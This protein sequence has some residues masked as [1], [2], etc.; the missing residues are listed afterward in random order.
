MKLMNT[1]TLLLCLFHKIL[2]VSFGKYHAV[3][4][5]TF[6]NAGSK[7]QPERQHPWHA[8]VDIL[9]SVLQCMTV[10]PQNELQKLSVQSVKTTSRTGFQR[11][12][13]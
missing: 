8:L 6:R 7:V 3:N 10:V 1:G 13:R 12:V 2:V 5:T 9:A 11:H 4:L